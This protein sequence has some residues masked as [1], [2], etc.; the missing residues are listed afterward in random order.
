[1]RLNLK[2]KELWLSQHF[3]KHHNLKAYERVAVQLPAF[4]PLALNRG[5]WSA[6]H[7]SHLTPCKIA[8]HIHLTGY[9]MTP[10]PVW[11]LW[12]KNKIS[13]LCQE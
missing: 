10:G 4:F 7:P 11:R 12:R 8:Q 5:K 9:W 3:I 1:M 2:V 13:C 6:S